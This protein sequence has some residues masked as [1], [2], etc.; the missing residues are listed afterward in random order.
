MARKQSEALSEELEILRTEIKVI[1]DKGDEA[2]EDEASR[3]EALLVEFQEKEAVRQKA[4]KREADVAEVMRAHLNPGNR[5]G[6]S[7]LGGAPQFQ[8]KTEAFTPESYQELSRSL[9]EGRP[10]DGEDAISRAKAATE[11]FNTTVTDASKQHITSLLEMDN[12]H[13]DLIARHIL[14]TGS[15]EYHQEF[16]RYVRSGGQYAGELMRTAMSLTT[17]NGG[18]LVPV[19]LDPTIVLTNA[20]AIN[21]LRDISSVVTIAGSNVFNGVTSAGVNA[22]WLGEGSQAADATP[23]FGQISVTAHKAAAYVFGSYEVLGDSNFA[24]Q[25]GMLM[26]DAKNRLES[27]A[28]ATANTGATIPRGVVAGVVA[29]TASIVTCSGA[30]GTFAVA[31][32]YNTYDALTPRSALNANWLGNPKIYSKVRQFSTNQG[33]N[34]WVTLGG[35]IPSELLGTPTRQATSMTSTVGAGTNILLCGDFSRYVIVDRI[36]FSLQYVP[37]V[38]GANQRP[39]GQ[40]GW[41]G[42]WRV[43]A[44]VA[45]PGAFRL[46]QLNQT[47]A[48]VALA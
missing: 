10:F 17:G 13:S 42:F 11:G 43:G 8:R 47:A 4:L 27:D 18:Y 2:T 24:S 3:A 6:G 28:M 38:V 40:A 34:F 37:A 48:A 20:G 14:M 25:L 7:Y 32:V 44:E 1:T 30:T 5:E 19:T 39:T 36:G 23:A 15:P 29:V 21:P 33:A 22:E 35:G 12:D 26:G 9:I 41:F 46:L 16:K 31:D 45:D